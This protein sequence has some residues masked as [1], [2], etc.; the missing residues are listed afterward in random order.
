MYDIIA[1]IQD[2]PDLEHI[3]ERYKW[4]EEIQGDQQAKFHVAVKSLLPNTSWATYCKQI[5]KNK[6]HISK[7]VVHYRDV[8]ELKEQDLQLP[9]NMTASLWDNVKGV[10]PKE[11]W[12][13]IGEVIE[14]YATDTPT[15]LQIVGYAK[16]KELRKKHDL[17]WNREALVHLDTLPTIYPELLNLEDPS[18]INLK[19]EYTRLNDIE[20]KRLEELKK[21]P[22]EDEELPPEPEEE[23]P[24]EPEE[25][26]EEDEEL[27][28]PE[29]EELPEEDEE[30]L[31]PEP[32][33]EALYKTLIE[34]LKG[35]HKD[36]VLRTL[37]AYLDP[38]IYTKY[39][40]ETA[41]P[42]KKTIA[43]ELRDLADAMNDLYNYVQM[44]NNYK[45]A[46]KPATDAEYC[47]EYFDILGIKGTPSKDKVVSIIKKQFKE[48]SKTHHPD[49][50][51]KVEDFHRLVEAKDKL[52]KEFSWN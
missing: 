24:P 19:A 32:D 21:L 42:T 35:T 26:P 4:L 45:F 1:D 47:R 37:K 23:L 44:R 28:E 43:R 7:L 2:T 5:G 12:L 39:V 40:V 31:P 22:E 49:K 51:G 36:K 18:L 9:N 11:K 38:A 30:E 14:E 15:K 25:L 46:P 6:S 27:P 34:D 50:G 10:D 3:V 8:E 13:Y 48:L 29:D 16:I 52:I 41:K 17:T 33:Y 20:L